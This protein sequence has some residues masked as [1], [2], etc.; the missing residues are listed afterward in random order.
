MGANRRQE[1]AAETRRRLVK[2]A[3][4]ILA[5]KG[6]DEITVSEIAR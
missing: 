2:A 3:G 6:I 1:A 5:H 4:R